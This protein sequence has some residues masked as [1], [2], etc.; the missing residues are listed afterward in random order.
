MDPVL[1]NR[2]SL[3]NGV[4]IRHSQMD[5]VL[6]NKVKFEH[7]IGVAGTAGRGNEI[8]G[9]LLSLR[10]VSNFFSKQAGYPFAIQMD[11][12]LANR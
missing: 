6:A 3:S 12:V 7:S 1:A 5:S 11:P 2:R 10:A 8:G 4:S 9:P